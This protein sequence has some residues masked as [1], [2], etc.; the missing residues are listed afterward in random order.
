MSVLDGIKNFLTFVNNNWT[1]IAVIISLII[2]I[3]KKIQAFLKQSN[4]KKIE[5]AKKHINETILKLVTDAEVDYEDWNKAGSIK[6][7]QV[8]NKIF[9]DYP[10]LSK[11][12]DQEELI[13]WIDDQIDKALKELREIVAKNAE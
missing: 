11:V 4:I 9:E 13:K 6:R 8:I 3:C 7:S 5:V 10:I 12:V 1:S 2:A